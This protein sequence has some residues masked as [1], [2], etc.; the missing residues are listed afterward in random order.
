VPVLIRRAGHD[1]S[2]FTVH[3]E[4]TEPVRSERL[5]VA[6]GRRADLR[7]LGVSAA[8]IDDTKPFIN[9][10][11]HLRAAADVWSVGDVTG[12][13][14]FTHVAMYQARIA[15][16]DILGEPHEPASY[17][18]LPR[19][20]FTDP[21]IGTVGRTEAQA[22]EANL[23]VRTAVSPIPSS[24]RGWIHGS[25]NDGL[26]KLVADADAEVLLGA[27]SAGPAGGEVL[28]ALAV[29]VH[30]QVPVGVLAEMI[31]AY[32]TFHRAIEDAITRLS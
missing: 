1:E 27:T 25:G 21:E 8:G 24:S 6:A 20:T 2:G 16:R 14:A 28:G 3:L 10:D 7:A 11:D 30:A 12:E 32:P 23:T 9:V 15:A 31:Y 5:L 22:R 17:R 19:V 18:A 29:A 13:G 4:G 26:I